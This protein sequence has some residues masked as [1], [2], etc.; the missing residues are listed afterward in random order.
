MRVF[1]KGT[2]AFEFFMNK[3]FRYSLNN[4]QRLMHLLN[5]SD[6]KR[7]SYDASECEWSE[8]IRRILL[9]L[10]YFYFHE[11]RVTSTWHRVMFK[12]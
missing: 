9:G 12:L 1:D 6:L 11:S 10:R 8:F 4:S 5:A 2:K 3:D 7:Y